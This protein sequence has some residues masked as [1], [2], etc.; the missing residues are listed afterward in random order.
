MLLLSALIVQFTLFSLQTKVFEWSSSVFPVLFISPRQ[1]HSSRRKQPSTSTWAGHI[2]HWYRRDRLPVPAGGGLLVPALPVTRHV[3][4]PRAGGSTQGG[5]ISP[6]RVA[7]ALKGVDALA[8]VIL[9]MKY[10]S[11]SGKQT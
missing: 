6:E 5:R 3:T 1:S 7:F 10:V 11:G 8:G 9:V 4:Q 2:T